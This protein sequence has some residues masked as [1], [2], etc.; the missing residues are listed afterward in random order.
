[1]RIAQL[2]PL[3][4]SVPPHGY[5]GT[6]LV[7]SHLTDDLVKMGHDVTLFA[8]ADSRTD[9]KLVSTAKTGVRAGGVPVHRWSCYE[10]QN[11]LALMRMQSQFDVIHNHL[12]FYALPFL[13][14]AD[15][16][17]VTTNHNP[18]MSYCRSI[19][20]EYSHQPYVSISDAY[21]KHNY[22]DRLNYVARVYN[23]IEV[24]AFHAVENPQQDYV[25]FIGRICQAKGTKEAIEIAKAVGKR[26][27]IAGKVDPADQDYFENSVKDLID[28]DKVKYIGEVNFS[29]KL[30]LY[31]NA[32]AV[33]YPINFEEPF[34]LV[35]AEA[36][37]SGTPTVALDRG[38]V[39]E[40]LSDKETAVI[41]SSVEELID[42]FQEIYSL[43][44]QACINRARKLFDR[45][46]MA[47]EYVKV[48]EN[49]M[50]R[51]EEKRD[52]LKEKMQSTLNCITATVSGKA[53]VHAGPILK[54]FQSA[55]EGN[56]TA[57]AARNG[58]D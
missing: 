45:K 31:Q 42:R 35:M 57:Q 22:G 52:P 40:V 55:T 24:D 29:Q 36:L 11:I 32:L 3:I 21:Q 23:G 26:L 56:G 34:G 41:G 58:N 20:F 30:E 38:S 9:A 8:T 6:E 1:M 39:R 7:V 33:I 14:N 28:G 15:C 17:V 5:G 13:E 16:A 51:K 54:T 25:L 46:K 37:A 12:G 49:L 4:E 43:E 27:I 18:I 19:Y 50:G 2:A 44:R 47:E 48:Y 53:S 10:L